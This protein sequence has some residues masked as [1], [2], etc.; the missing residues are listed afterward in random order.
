MCHYHTN[1]SQREIRREKSWRQKSR[2]A[3]RSVWR[4]R[5][6]VWPRPSW[7]RFYTPARPAL[8]DWSRH[9]ESPAAVTPGPG[10]QLQVFTPPPPP[11][12]LDWS[13]GR[14]SVLSPSGQGHGNVSRHELILSKSG[15]KGIADQTR[16]DDAKCLE[17]RKI[18][19]FFENPLLLF[20]LEVRSSKA[21]SSV[22]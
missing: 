8:R 12:D 7:G 9:R 1:Q 16:G 3:T 10:K 14:K 21:P 13:P 17:S 2:A 4:R 19:A 18:I 20:R 15:F 5:M 22:S 6:I 11:D